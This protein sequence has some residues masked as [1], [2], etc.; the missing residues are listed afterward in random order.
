M[1]ATKYFDDCYYNNAYY[2]KVGGVSS[3]EMNALELDF[4]FLIN[5]S[6]SVSS[7][8][9]ERYQAELN[10]HSSRLQLF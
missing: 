3:L 9:F 4:L 2:A 6:L 8:L 10:K 7:D 1:L 5:F